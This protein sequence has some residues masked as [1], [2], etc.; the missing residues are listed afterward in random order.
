MQENQLSTRKTTPTRLTFGVRGQ[1][2]YIGQTCRFL[3]ARLLEDARSIKNKDNKTAFAE[4]AIPY[5]E[6]ISLPF[7]DLLLLFNKKL[8]TFS[9]TASYKTLCPK[10]FESNLNFKRLI[11]SILTKLKF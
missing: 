11:F 1:K 9:T 6:K 4:Y 10:V 8:L 2:K 3:H 7:N 5:M